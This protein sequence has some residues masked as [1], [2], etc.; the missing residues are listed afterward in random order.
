M[1]NART[2]L[3]G[4]FLT[5]AAAAV[6]A[7]AQANDGPPDFAEMRQRMMDRMKEMIGANDDEWK[8]MQ[9]KI[10]KIQQLQRDVYPRGMP[11]M[12][13]PGGPDGGGPGGP[14]PGGAAGPGGGGIFLGPPP[15]GPD[16]DN[17]SDVPQKLRDLREALQNKDTPADDLKAKEQAYRDAKAAAKVELAKAQDD[18]KE[19]VTKAP[20]EAA[21]VSIGILE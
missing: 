13:G 2:L 4:L 9:P 3:L 5:T 7:H 20:Q 19:S 6:P 21:L 11:M 17:P 8:A 10:E 16:G 15:G 1:M 14:P 12:F 18:L